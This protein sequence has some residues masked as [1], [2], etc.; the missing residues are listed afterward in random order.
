MQIIRA[1]SV[2]GEKG[3]GAG[4]TPPDPRRIGSGF[5]LWNEMREMAGG[6]RVMINLLEYQEHL[7]PA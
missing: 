3:E 2:N 5:N 6:L 4:P 1:S 7:K